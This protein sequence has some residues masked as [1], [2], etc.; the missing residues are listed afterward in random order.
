MVYTS[1]IYARF[2]DTSITAIRYDKIHDTR[3]QRIERYVDKIRV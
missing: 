1:K 2:K 3:R